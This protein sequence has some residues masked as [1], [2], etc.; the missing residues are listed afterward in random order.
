MKIIISKHIV[1]DK[2][3]LLRK[4]GFTVTQYQIKDLIKNPEHIDRES[5][6]PKIIV[7][8]EFDEKHILRVVYKIQDGISK[9][10]D[11]STFGV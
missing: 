3:P 9:A 1:K 10:C 11:S 6:A 2:I 8:R 4:H 5:D 7:S